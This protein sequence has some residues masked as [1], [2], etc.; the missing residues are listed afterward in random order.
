M[1]KQSLLVLVGIAFFL[2]SCSNT[3]SEMANEDPDPTDCV[4]QYPEMDITYSNYV[5]GILTQYCIECHH[6]GNSQGPGDFSTYNGVSQ[7]LG[8]FNTRVLSN[9]ADMPQGNA[10]LPQAIRDSLMV[11]IANCSP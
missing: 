7:Y 1:K 4:P 6:E 8:S 9:N 5:K 3:A 2:G 10:P 11:W